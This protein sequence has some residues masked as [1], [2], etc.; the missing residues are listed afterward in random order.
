MKN[1]PSSFYEYAFNNGIDQFQ[2]TLDF[3]LRHEILTPEAI[4][5][6]SDSQLYHL[7]KSYFSAPMTDE[8]LSL[9]MDG[10]FY[11]FARWLEEERNNVVH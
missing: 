6:F 9:F 5:L 3:F 10:Y 7:F 1:D 8:S 2:L 4:R 11:A